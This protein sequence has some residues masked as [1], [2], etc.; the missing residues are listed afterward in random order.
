MKSYFKINQAPKKSCFT[1]TLSS[2]T[3]YLTSALIISVVHTI[4][5]NSI[6]FCVDQQCNTCSDT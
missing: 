4:S 3:F 2:L 1:L 5:Q 6:S